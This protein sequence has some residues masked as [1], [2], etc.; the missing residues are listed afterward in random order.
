ML[1]DT[2]QLNEDN[3]IQDK[4]KETIKQMDIGYQQMAEINLGLVN[5]WYSIENE[6]EV[7]NEGIW[8]GEK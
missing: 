6:A 2:K 5:E 3:R 7:I 8:K 4:F 1:I